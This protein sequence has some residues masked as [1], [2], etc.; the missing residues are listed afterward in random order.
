MNNAKERLKELGMTQKELAAEMGVST[1]AVSNWINRAVIPSPKHQQF[2]K[3]RFGIIFDGKMKPMIVHQPIMPLPLIPKEPKGFGSIDSTSELWA[4]TTDVMNFMN[5]SEKYS[6]TVRY[7]SSFLVTCALGRATC[8]QKVDEISAV[9]AHDTFEEYLIDEC[10]LIKE[11][12]LRQ[13]SRTES[14]DIV[15]PDITDYADYVANDIDPAQETSVEEDTSQQFLYSTG[16][17]QSILKEVHESWEDFLIIFPQDSSK[18]LYTE[19]VVCCMEVIRNLIAE[20]AAQ[21]AK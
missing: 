20:C 14:A 13:L 10:K 18:A 4:K 11:K 15:F 8:F 19:T 16:N 7:I 6:H 3:E 17:N 5:I 1:M 2:L 9:P 12:F 21:N